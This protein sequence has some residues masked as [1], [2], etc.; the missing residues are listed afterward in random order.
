ME[1]WCLWK[2]IESKSLLRGFELNNTS[3]VIDGDSI[4]R[5]LYKIH[6]IHRKGNPQ[7]DYNNYA[8]YIELFFKMLCNHQITPYV[9]FEGGIRDIKFKSIIV[10]YRLKRLIDLPP[11]VFI[12]NKVQYFPLF[13]RNVFEYVLRKLKIKTVRCDFES[14]GEVV[15]IARSLNCPVLSSNPNYFF[16]A[17]IVYLPFQSVCLTEVNPYSSSIRPTTGGN[18]EIKYIPC[19]AFDM[20]GFLK[21]LELTSDKLPLLIAILETDAYEF[22]KYASLF[23]KAHHPCEHISNIASWIRERSVEAA[24]QEFLNIAQ[25]TADRE[26]LQQKMESFKCVVKCYKSKHSSYL[27]ICSNHDFP[28]NNFDLQYGEKMSEI[29]DIFLENFRKCR[30][31]PYLMD[32][33]IHNQYF[34]FKPQLEKINSI[35]SHHLSEKIVNA[36]H[37]ILTNSVSN[38]TCLVREGE[39][40][41]EKVFPVSEI[42]APSFIEIQDIYIDD[43]KLL[44]LKILGVHTM[45]DT[46]LSFS[47]RFQLFITSIYYIENIS[48]LPIFFRYS[49]IICVIILGHIYDD[50]KRSVHCSDTIHK[51]N[52]N[53]NIPSTLQGDENRDNPIKASEIFYF[54]DYFENKETNLFDKDLMHC[55]SQFQSCLLHI[56]LLN[57]VLNMPFPEFLI[58]EYLNNTFIYNLCKTFEKQTLPIVDDFI[59]ELVTAAPEIISTFLKMNNKLM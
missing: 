19:A 50:K 35:H 38:L 45:K 12:E 3:L 29:P 48:P 30:Y 44:I 13:M 54:K 43:R 26:K 37:K 22:P 47:E 16:C 24:I 14:F 41:V 28:E 42:D 9:I 33:Y 36:I 1:P 55:M 21:H 8:E 10:S 4:S 49:L 31:S 34:G 57:D 15:S 39:C 23:P 2:Y 56:N 11:N 32:I 7:G 46:I 17:E 58:A 20:N 5:E 6:V 59:K 51:E 40:M 25:T 27:E 18:P 53:L 52:I